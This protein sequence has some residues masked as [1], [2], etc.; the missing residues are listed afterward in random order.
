[1]NF[2]PAL[3]RLGES[4]PICEY[5]GRQET[6]FNCIKNLRYKAACC[7]RLGSTG[8]RFHYQLI[9]PCGYEMTFSTIGH[10]R[11]ITN[12]RALSIASQEAP[13]CL[14]VESLSGISSRR[15]RTSD[16]YR[17]FLSLLYTD[18]H[19]RTQAMLAYNVGCQSPKGYSTIYHQQ[20][21]F[22]QNHGLPTTPTRL[23]TTDF[24]GQLQVWQCQEDRL[25]IFM[26]M[27]KHVLCSPV[28]C[29]LS[30][31]GLIESTHS[32]GDEEP[33]TYIGGA[34]PINWSCN[35]HSTRGVRDHH[36]VLVDITTHSA[37]GR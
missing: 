17:W 14:H 37:I 3:L 5:W 8:P 30:R 6:L 4:S 11:H 7:W 18:P 2:F 27:N 9:W 35:C 23:F 32:W 28:V 20:L 24:V 21:W 1:M 15:G 19:H 12:T 25:L 33:H 26:D 31:M 29:C 36:T 34:E 13:P 10:T 16:L 22:I